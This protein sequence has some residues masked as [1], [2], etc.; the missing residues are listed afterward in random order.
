MKKPSRGL[1]IAVVVLGMFLLLSIVINA[2]LFI[3][4]ISG[5]GSAM[6]DDHADDEY[7]QFTEQW[8]YG[9]GEAKAVRIQVSGLIFRDASEGLFVPAYD[10]I[11][12]IL[13]QVR[14]ARN[15]PA[16][17]AIVVEVDSPGGALTP[18]DEIYHELMRF[19]ADD[20]DRKIIVHM[21]DLAASGGY[22]VAMAG[23]WLI[24]EPTAIVGSIGVIMQTLNWKD[25]SEK[26]G[27]RATTVVSGDNKDMLNPFEEVNEAQVALVQQMIDN[28]YARF[29]GIVKESRGLREEELKTLADGR[30]LTADE[31]LS[32][33]LIDEIGYWEDVVSRT[34]QLLD[35][36]EVSFVRYEQTPS[37]LDWLTGVHSPVSLRSL[38]AARTPRL[39][40]LWHP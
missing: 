25:L 19:K 9:R 22:Y 3:S 26:I 15:D 40:S 10:K 18:S 11:E 29:V 37:F 33:K 17:R 24:A 35:A 38:Q 6:V 23:D 32:H 31:A 14:A 34:Q 30:I 28:M 4:M 7:P 21:Q 2:G 39:M 8:S 13:R 1:W 27:L 5:W 20:P 12:T 36:E 16:V